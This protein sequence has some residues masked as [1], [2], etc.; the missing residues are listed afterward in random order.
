[1]ER[2]I[3]I[4]FSSHRVETLSWAEKFMQESQV[5]FLEEPENEILQRFLRDE[6]SLEKYLK[7]KE[8]QFPV[9][10]EK[11]AKI[12]KDLYQKGKEV[13]AVEPYL[14]RVGRIY[15]LLEEGK[16]PS[17]ILTHQELRKVYEIE[18]KVTGALLD[19]YQASLGSDFKVLLEKV[20]IFSKFDAERFRLRDR[21]RAKAIIKMLPPSGKVYVEAGTIH[22]FLKK[23]LRAKLKNTWT[24][25]SKYLLEDFVKGEKGRRWIYPPGELL[26]LRYIFKVKENEEIENLLSARSLIYILL[27][28]KEERIPT[29][30][31]PFPHLREE[32]QIIQKLNSFSLLDCSF[33]YPKLRF[34]EREVALKIF[35]NY[36]LDKFRKETS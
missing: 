36:Y 33:I 10:A 18:R 2:K 4:G 5:I 17:E 28:E 27:I 6:I 19:F 9:F 12:V 23:Y 11:M 13:L 15:Q 22:L 24:V 16:E 29:E 34:R 26:T 8:F 25:R 30:D 7:M 14:E 35:E 1:M 3:L 32:L 31:N 21:L 20:K